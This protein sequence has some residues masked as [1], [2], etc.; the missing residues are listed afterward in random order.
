M[1]LYIAHSAAL[2]TGTT[3]SAGQSVA[4]TTTV[5]T[6]L[7]Q[8]NVP[9]NAVINLVEFGWSQDIATATASNVEVA[10]TDTATTGLTTHTTTTIKPLLNNQASA[11]TLTMGTGATGY[12]AVSVVTNTTLRPL[13]HLYVPQQYVYQWPLG[14]YP[15]V[16]GSTTESFVQVRAKTTATVNV[17]TWLIWDEA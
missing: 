13:V 1:T 7:L 12:G 14:N 9:D 4:A 10:T 11:S 8:L 5:Q 17:L 2:S 6:V 3:V 15:V 16:G